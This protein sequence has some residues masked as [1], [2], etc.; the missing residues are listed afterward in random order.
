MYAKLIFK[1]ARRSIKDYLIYLVTMTICV[2]LFYAFLSI[3]SVSYHP[4]LKA[5]Y[6]LTELRDGMKLSICALTLLLLFLIRYVNHFMLLHRQKEFA[7]H[8]VIGMEQRTIGWLFFAETL[9][10]G[11][12]AVVLGIFLGMI[13]S[14]FI[15][16]M[17]LSDF[18]EAYQFTWMLFP[19]TVLLTAGFFTCCLLLVGLFNLRSIQRTKLI[20]MLS[21][22]RQ[23]EPPLRKSRLMYYLT[24]LY[25]LMLGLMVF[26]GIQMITCYFDPRFALPVH[27]LYWGLI[28]APALGIALPL[29]WLVVFG[30]RKKQQKPAAFHHL[31][32]IEMGFTLLNAVFAA[33]VPVMKRSYL[34]PYG[35]GVMRQYLMF[36]IGNILLFICLFVYLSSLAAEAWKE[37]SPQHRYKEENLFFYGQILS[38]L[39]GN[40]K[41]M[42]LI[43]ITLVL[44]IFLFL[45]A[46]VLT[47]WSLGYLD[48]RS[49]YDVQLS[50]RYNTVYE[51]KDLPHS[52]YPAVSTF[53][54][55]R[56][57]RTAYD[58]SFSLYLPKRS[59]FNIRVK[60]DFPVLALSLSDYNAIREMLD[61]EPITLEENT[62]TTQWK[63]IATTDERDAFL[64][65]HPTVSTDAGILSLSGNSSYEALIGAT[66]Y[67][68]YT[69]VV[70]VFSDQICEQ[71]LSVN[72]SRYIQTAAELSFADAQALEKAFLRAYPEEANRSA[73]SGTD[74]PIGAQYFIRLHT[75]E[76]NSI[77][78]SNF[79]LKA[80]MIYGAVV[81]MVICLTI[82]SLQQLM[83]ASQYRYR[84]H[85]LH[86]LGV[87]ETH[88]R[89]LILRQL[90]LWFGLPVALALF[91]S[92]VVSGSFLQSIS[93]QIHAYIGAGALF[94]QLGV[95]I[96]ILLWLL[97][98]YFISTWILF[99]RSVA[100]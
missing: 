89:R 65:S 63:S 6:N 98:C 48:A 70:Y 21:A 87:E 3:S 60:W 14:Q 77:L 20:D 9:C 73:S 36:L 93:A 66:V 99:W 54:A 81:L 91:V 51:E 22:Q 28:L 39:S 33:C 84:F 10:M 95:T 74:A 57:I 16:A 17:L 35:T 41:S 76:V 71:L 12:V 80:S 68:S 56:G 11:A 46:P 5:A 67:N 24:G 53:L 7:I 88:I 64:K 4:A 25:L 43:S 83:D 30:I 97:V 72:C 45:A 49:R 78:A 44:S 69:D 32:L 59:D 79:V 55:D 23:N 94:A 42:T 13:V 47:Q 50:S 62:F 29:L 8:A 31:F 34:L 92:G 40:T 15:T 1:N 26:N 61:L 86:K 37:Y 96:G 27:V 85:V 82:L 52:S 19:D 75:L 38:K 2:T 100:P 18:G 58:H 90:G